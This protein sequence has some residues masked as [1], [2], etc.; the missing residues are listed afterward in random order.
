MLLI[1]QICL[2]L[3]AAGSV[4]AS[5]NAVE[6]QGTNW[7]REVTYG[8]EPGVPFVLLSTS[9]IDNHLLAGCGY[10]YLEAKGPVKLRGTKG[11]IYS[12]LTPCV[13]YEVA[14]EGKGKW[15]T[16]ARSTPAPNSLT[17]EIGPTRPRVLLNVDMEPFRSSIGKI[18]WGRLLLEN[19]EAATFQIDDLLPAGNSPDASAGNFKQDV[20][21]LHPNRFGSSF[22]LI[23]VTSF[24]KQLVGDFI[25]VGGGEGASIDIRGARDGN[26][27]FWPSVLLQVG[28]SEK[29]WQTLGKVTHKGT[30]TLLKVFH[31]GPWE[32]LRIDMDRFKP[33]AGKF[34]YGKI[35]FSNGDFAVFELRDLRPQ[36]RQT[37]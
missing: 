6:S 32:N 5:E 22:S 8:M 29:D 18:R 2:I 20:T 15:K 19:G 17:I 24:L 7:S 34:T 23:K 35:V 4:T 14:T 11:D 30:Q 36:I 26:E 33:V 9:S 28:N 31:N 13:I 10:Q 16:I 21:D 12:D 1:G 27:D 25:F 3:F 37:N